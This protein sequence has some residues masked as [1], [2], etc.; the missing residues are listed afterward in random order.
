MVKKVE[1]NTEKNEE[2]NIKEVVEEVQVDTEVVEEV[3]EEVVEEEVKEEPVVTIDVEAVTQKE[4][5]DS[6]VV[7]GDTKVD[8][9][10]LPERT[11]RIR[12]RVNHRCTIG[13]EFYDLK[14]GQCYN[15]PISV[16]KRLNKAGILSPL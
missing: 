6:K 9:S 5:E 11:V 8:T 14:E 15:V 2:K 1:K 4:E 12:L 3:K 13:G 7:I 16:K 10:T